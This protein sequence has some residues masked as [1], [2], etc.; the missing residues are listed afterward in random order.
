MH[1]L[2]AAALNYLVLTLPAPA[3]ELVDIG[4]P[5]WS[6]TIACISA[7]AGNALKAL[8]ARRWH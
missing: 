3:R 6:A 1:L 7:R 8:G 4:V 5:G 2:G